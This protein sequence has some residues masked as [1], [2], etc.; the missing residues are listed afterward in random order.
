VRRIISFLR[1]VLALPAGLLAGAVVWFSTSV[2]LDAFGVEFPNWL[3]FLVM[4]YAW[5]ATG[6]VFAGTATKLAPGARTRVAQLMI[7]IA[8]AGALLLVLRGEYG[9]AASVVFGLSLLAGAVGYALRLRGFTE[10]INAGT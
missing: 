2:L 10:P 6:F 5:M 7:A 1:W 4:A 3:F 8:L 9:V